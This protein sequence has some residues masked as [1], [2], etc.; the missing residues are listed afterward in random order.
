MITVLLF[1]TEK[2][3]QEMSYKNDGSLFRWI[4]FLKVMNAF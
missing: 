3:E 1:I 2:G 4:L